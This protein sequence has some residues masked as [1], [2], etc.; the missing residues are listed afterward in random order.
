[1]NTPLDQKLQSLELQLKKMQQQNAELNR[2]IA[3]LERENNRRKND[4]NFLQNV[5]Q[6]I[7]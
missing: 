7:R 4:I 3:F 1:V 2:K 5:I 6:K